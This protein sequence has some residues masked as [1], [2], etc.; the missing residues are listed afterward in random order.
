MKF[1]QKVLM[2]VEDTYVEFKN[3]TAS[4]APSGPQT[5]ALQTNDSAN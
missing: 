2:T 1:Q 3:A 5:F 4:V